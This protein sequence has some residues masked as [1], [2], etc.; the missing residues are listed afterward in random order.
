MTRFAVLAALLLFTRSL[1]AQQADSLAV[2]SRIVSAQPDN[3]R[4]VFHLAGLQPRGSAQAVALYERYTRLEPDDAW[5]YLALAEAQAA[6]RQF[7]AALRSV[8][9]AARVAPGAEDVNIVRQ[10]IQRARH[11]SVPVLAPRSS[12]TSDSD[13]NRLMQLSLAGDVASGAQSRF[14]LAAS[15][16]RTSDGF[17]SFNTNEARTYVSGKSPT[18][19]FELSAG[20]ALVQATTDQTVA[21]GRGRLRLIGRNAGPLFDVRASRAPLLVSPLLVVN[22]VVLSEARATVELPLGRTF[23]LRGSGQIGDLASQNV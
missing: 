22:H 21:V 16:A 3:S 1:A 10:R 5:G 7:E 11:N 18:S 20:A 12:Y 8:Q 14:G 6:A 19:Q 15:R 9:H 23:R 4:A 17:E 2:Y 13:G